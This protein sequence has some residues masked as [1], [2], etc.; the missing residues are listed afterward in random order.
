MTLIA[1]GL[2]FDN[3]EMVCTKVA[4]AESLT[5]RPG[6]DFGVELGGSTELG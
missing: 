6:Q 2:A 3:K 4:R 1:C 5:L